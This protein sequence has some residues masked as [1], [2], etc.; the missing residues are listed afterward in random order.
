M[1][2]RLCCKS[3]RQGRGLDGRNA[4]C[5]LSVVY[6]PAEGST[7]RELK[8]C[9]GLAAARGAGGIAIQLYAVLGVQ[10]KSNMKLRVQ[11]HDPV[12]AAAQWSMCLDRST[13]AAVC[14]GHRRC[15]QV[16]RTHTAVCSAHSMRHTLHW[17]PLEPV[18]ASWVTGLLL[19]R[20]TGFHSTWYE[21]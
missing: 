12:A 15:A 18:S 19:A 13:S 5:V 17:P 16:D 2:Q 9:G 3:Q 1:L 10:Y 21:L 6:R 7:I 20:N 8:A 14:T 4:C 11:G